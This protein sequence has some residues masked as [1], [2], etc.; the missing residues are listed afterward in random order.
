[1]NLIMKQGFQKVLKW[2]SGTGR[3]SSFD[4]L[5]CLLQGDCYDQS[6]WQHIIK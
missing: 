1:M 6:N 3:V 5:A 4:K 2:A